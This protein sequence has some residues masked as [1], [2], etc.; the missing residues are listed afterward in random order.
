MPAFDMAAA[1]ASEER[2]N[3]IAKPLGSLGR[4]ERMVVRIAGFTGDSRYSIAKR[5]LLVLCA[6]NGVAHRGVCQAGS[7][8][9]AALARC[10]ARGNISVCKMASVAKV[11]VVG[12]DMGMAEDARLPKK[13]LNRRVA[14]G[15]AD[16]SVGPAMTRK[17][18]VAAIQHGI[19]LAKAMKKKGYRLLLTGEIGMGNT[20]TSSALAAVLLG[21]GPAEVTGRGAGLSDEGLRRKI[22][23]IE[24][25]IA[26]NRPDPGDALDVLAKLGG[27]DIAGMAGIF[28]G[29][30][31]HRIPVLVDGFISSMAALVALRLCPRAGDAMLA[32][33]VSAEPAGKLILNELGLEPLICADLCLG[34]G[35]GA[36]AALPLLD[37]A[38]A[39]YNDMITYGD[40]AAAAGKPRA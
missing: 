4:L 34:E 13:F 25:A 1:K 15:T 21:R 38:Y 19:D 14:A 11:D 6:D 29:G 12:V 37:M 22:G 26:R 5:V 23:V 10:L 36:V 33:H 30:A 18:A 17:Q 2:W 31:Q 40:L 16:L 39:V 27:F 7:E 32:S 24:N 3:S 35:T 20:T 28:L 9:T 8:V